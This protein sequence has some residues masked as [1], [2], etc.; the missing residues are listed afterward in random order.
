MIKKIQYL[1]FIIIVNVHFIFKVNFSWNLENLVKDMTQMT[2]LKFSLS[3]YY[4]IHSV[5][6]KWT[7]ENDIE[8]KE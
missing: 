8:Q 6:Q 7:K 3:K 4:C 5:Y 2:K 1:R